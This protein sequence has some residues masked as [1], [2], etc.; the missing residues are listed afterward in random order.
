[1]QKAIIGIILAST[2]SA[3][4]GGGTDTAEVA[5]F[6]ATGGI[7]FVRA[8]N[9]SE[10]VRWR[11]PAEGTLEIWFDPELNISEAGTYV[12]GTAIINSNSSVQINRG[13]VT[14]DSTV[15]AKTLNAPVNRPT[16]AMTYSGQAVMLIDLVDV[17]EG[18]TDTIQQ[19]GTATMNMNFDSNV[20]SLSVTSNDATTRVSSSVNTYSGTNL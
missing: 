5:G 17:S 12:A 19:F 9:P 15:Y 11:I 7:S 18:V 3:C 16:G 1:M 8:D 4:G 13:I 14:G 2:V 10:G 20:G 6:I